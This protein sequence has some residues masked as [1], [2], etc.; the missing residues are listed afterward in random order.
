MNSE[1][2][3]IDNQR[4]GLEMQAKADTTVRDTLYFEPCNFTLNRFQEFVFT[5][6]TEMWMQLLTFQTFPGV[7][8]D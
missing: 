5:T 8:Q 3:I 7:K 1:T 6:R 2:I 4:F